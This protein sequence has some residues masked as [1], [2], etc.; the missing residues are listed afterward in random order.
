MQVVTVVVNG[1]WSRRLR[2]HSYEAKSG[3]GVI[4]GQKTGKILFAGVRSKF[5]TVY[6]PGLSVE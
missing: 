2:K 6:T 3:V 4:I 1:E 5:W